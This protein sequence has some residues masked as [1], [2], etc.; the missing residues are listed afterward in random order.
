M[1]GGLDTSW[2]RSAG[3]LLVAAA[4]VWAGLRERR[5]VQDNPNLWPT[6]WYLTGALFLVM[7]LGRILDIGGI[8]S[9]IGRLEAQNG[10]WYNSR[11]KYQALLVGA[12][13]GIWFVA[14]LVALWRVPERRRRYLPM[15]L[16]VFTIIG[17]AGVRV[18]SLHQIDGLLY[19]R[20]IAGLKFSAIFELFFLVLALAMTFWQ[21]RPLPPEP[22]PV[23]RP[24][25]AYSRAASSTASASIC[26]V[27]SAPTASP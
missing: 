5:R 15:T 11:R 6:F 8:V 9:E 25:R 1:L 2:L 22:A 17:F 19:R 23:P 20:G 16:L 10:G 26:G 7:G 13:G 14:V 27:G 24:E 12:V 18:V 4:A 3:Y 21:P